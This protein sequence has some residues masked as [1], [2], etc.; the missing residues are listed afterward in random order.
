MWPDCV[1]KKKIPTKQYKIIISCAVAFFFVVEKQNEE[2][3]E[4]NER[5]QW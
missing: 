2:N 5:L 1:K 4:R 3:E